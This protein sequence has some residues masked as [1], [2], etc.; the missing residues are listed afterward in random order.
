MLS[1]CCAEVCAGFS[2]RVVLRKRPNLV[3]W[4]AIEYSIMARSICRLLVSTAETKLSRAKALGNRGSPATY[5][6]GE[7]LKVILSKVVNTRSVGTNG[8]LFSAGEA[9]NGWVPWCLVTTKNAHKVDPRKRKA[10]GTR[11]AATLKDV[12]RGTGLRL[13]SISLNAKRGVKLTDR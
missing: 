1:C 12:L 11:T 8:G 9:K 7:W 5:R 13:E 3:P 4:S 2:E 10:I 6:E